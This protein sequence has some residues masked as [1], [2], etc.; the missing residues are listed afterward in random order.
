M[1]V[2]SVDARRGGGALERGRKGAIEGAG[3]S[4]RR[5]RRKE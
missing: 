5:K 1:E 2:G 4:K 3:R